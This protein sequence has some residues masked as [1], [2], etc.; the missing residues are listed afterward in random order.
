[1]AQAT[2]A[3]DTLELIE[4][5]ANFDEFDDS[6]GGIGVVRAV[7]IAVGVATIAAVVAAVLF[8]RTGNSDESFD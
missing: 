5:P 4:T 6:D 1:M 7:L 8:R 3:P 2:S